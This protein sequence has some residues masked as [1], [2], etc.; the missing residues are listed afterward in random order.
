MELIEMSFEDWHQKA[1]DIKTDAPDQERFYFRI[2]A[3]KKGPHEFLYEE[4]PIFEPVDN[5]FF[6]VE[7]KEQRGINCR[8]GMKGVIAETHYDQSRNFIVL[9]KG[10]RRY[11]LTHP[12]Y[13][14][15]LG[16][17]PMI[18]PSGRH[19]AIDWTNPDLS[20]FPTFREVEVQEVVLQ[21]GDALYLPTFWF[22]FIVSLN[23]NYQCNAR[24]GTTMEHV[25]H[26]HECGFQ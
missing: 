12:K 5:N 9:L 18:H 7:P 13:C 26:V 6:M 4:L 2:N 17:Y 22:H 10:Q 1:E 16:L 8:F 3:V 19:S 24:S 15:G 14:K 11:V 25:H 21:A 23:L 20:K